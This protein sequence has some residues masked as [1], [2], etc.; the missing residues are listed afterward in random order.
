MRTWLLLLGPILMASGALLHALLLGWKPEPW[1][2]DIERARTGARRTE[3]C[4]GQV[5]TEH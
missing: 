4:T 5:R 1:G 3:G 2:G